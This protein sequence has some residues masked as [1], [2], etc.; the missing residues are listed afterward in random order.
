MKFGQLTEC[1]AR[2]NKNHSENE[3]VRLVPDLF[4]S[5]E[6][7]LDEAKASG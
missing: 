1:N 3:T 4:L 5:F 6:K 7:N 2:N